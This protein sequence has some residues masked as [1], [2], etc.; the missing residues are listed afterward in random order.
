MSASCDRDFEERRFD[1]LDLSTEREL[2]ERRFDSLDLSTE[3]ELEERKFDSPDLSSDRDLEEGRR[4]FVNPLEY[5]VSSQQDRSPNTA[6][7]ITNSYRNNFSIL[8]DALNAD[9]KDAV[10][11]KT[12]DASPRNFNDVMG[13]ISSDPPAIYT[14]P[15]SP[16]AQP[17]DLFPTVD[18]CP[19]IQNSLAQSISPLQGTPQD[20]TT[21]YFQFQ[22]PLLKDLTTSNVSLNPN[23]PV[24]SSVHHSKDVSMSIVL[25]AN[26]HE[27]QTSTLHGQEGALPFFHFRF[28]RD[29]VGPWVGTP[30]W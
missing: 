7:S 18:R 14:P 10:D 17:F 26:V 16:T 4:D 3:R 8:Q 12:L 25:L 21:S 5:V 20:L 15:R 13:F 2:E 22:P 30:M 1:I 23:L 11:V 19:A 9:N 6:R 27:P 24:F 29:D 28:G